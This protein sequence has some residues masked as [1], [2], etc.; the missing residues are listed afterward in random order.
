MTLFDRSRTTSYWRCVVTT[1][2]SG[3]FSKIN[4]DIGRKQRFLPR[5]AYAQRGLGRCKMSVRLSVPLST[6]VL[7]LN[8]YTYPHRVVK[9]RARENCVNG[10][11]RIDRS[12]TTSYW[13]S[14]V[15]TALSGVFSK[16][17]RDI[18]RKQRFFHTSP[19]FDAPVKDE[20][21]G[22]SSKHFV[23]KN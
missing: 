21:V 22:I 11:S 14:V 1:A 6:P 23:R 5:D 19:A 9:L 7:C 18:G 16:I 17:N 12:H 3:V 15:T 2:I 20:L 4:Q 10:H 13:H 8:G